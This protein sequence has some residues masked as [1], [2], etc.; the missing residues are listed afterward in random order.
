[1][2]KEGYAVTYT[3]TPVGTAAVKGAKNVEAGKDLTFTVK[4]QVGYVID[5]VTANGESL[6]QL[7][8]M[9]TD[10]NAETGVKRFVVRK[11]RKSRKSL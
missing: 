6:K 11:L 4:P 1:M 7:K 2:S 9:I 10:S 5:S 8:R 3:V